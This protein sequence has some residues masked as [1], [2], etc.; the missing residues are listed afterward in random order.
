MLRYGKHNKGDHPCREIIHHRDPGTGVAPSVQAVFKIFLGEETKRV[1]ATTCRRIR[2]SWKHHEIMTLL[3]P[4]LDC[5][6]AAGPDHVRFIGRTGNPHLTGCFERPM[7]TDET[8]LIY[9]T[10]GNSEQ[11]V[12]GQISP[13]IISP[14]TLSV[15]AFPIP[16]TPLRALDTLSQGVSFFLF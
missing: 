14:P 8:V 9:C 1:S 6:P 13:P 7:R 2:V 12:K 3:C 5:F 15:A 10:S 4:C 16:P 11:T